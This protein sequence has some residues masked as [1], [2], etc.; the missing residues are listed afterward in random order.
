MTN[1][2]RI[3]E[4]RKSYGYSQEYLAEKMNVSRQAVSKWE[5]DL[6]AP[7]TYNLIALAEL[8]DVS[9]EY[10]ATGKKPV[11][12]QEMP[13]A[14]PAPQHRGIGAGQ[15]VGMILLCMGLFALILGFLFSEELIGIGAILMI[16]AIPCL[17]MRRYLGMA[18]MWLTTVLLFF[19]SAMLM[20]VRVV[21]S[22]PSGGVT[23][24]SN[25]SLL[26]LGILVASILVTVVITVKAIRKRF[27]K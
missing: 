2:Q 24:R 19:L 25:L 22:A 27:R 9:V 16:Y 6:S 18:L 23:V 14:P 4:L 26:L 5:Q 17:A 3:S 15:I 20:P 12:P 11:T 21:G 8:L 10:L 1:G 13:P 7:D